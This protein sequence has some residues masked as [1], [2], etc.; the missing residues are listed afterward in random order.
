VTISIFVV[1]LVCIWFDKVMGSIWRKAATV[2][3]AAALIALM[4]TGSAERHGRGGW[5]GLMG[6]VAYLF[7]VR[8]RSYKSILMV[9]AVVAVM[10]AGYFTLPSFQSL[11][12][13]TRT[14]EELRDE[15]GFQSKY[16]MIDQGARVTE[17]THEAPKIVAH[18]FLGT[19][20]FHR[21]GTGLW[22][23]GS[24]NFFIQM[25][26]ETG[27]VGG[28]LLIMFVIRLWTVCGKPLVRLTR[29]S[30]PCR[31]AL[32]SACI[33]GMT[34]EYFYGGLPL[35]VVVAIVAPVLSL[36][37]VTDDQLALAIAPSMEAV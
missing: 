9:T 36:P 28:V 2:T 24:H 8:S 7:I 18:P 29:Y 27:A 22:S 11:V 10:V 15:N 26:L 32:L 16:G 5:L 14:G 19:G 3:M 12:D 25:F 17:W 23:S 21:E 35:L 13:F 30:T 20:F 6:G 31:V 4:M 34:G 1:Y 37:A 33:S